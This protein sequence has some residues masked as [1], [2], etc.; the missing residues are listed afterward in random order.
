[1]TETRTRPNGADAPVSELV[2]DVARDLSTLVRKEMDL[3][4][5]ETKQEVAKAAQAGGAFAGAGLAVWLTVIFLSLAAMFG[6]GAWLALGWAA[7]IVAGAWGLLAAVLALIGRSR[8]KTVNPVPV[9]TIET[10][11]EDVRW[12]RERNGKRNG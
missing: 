6:L 12:L 1:M 8:M 11:K 10:V 4:K 3:A 9:Q 2:S 5:A 7:L